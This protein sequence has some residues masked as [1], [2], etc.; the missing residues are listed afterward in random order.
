MKKEEN[1][2]IQKLKEWFESED[3]KKMTEAWAV[4]A[5][6]D[7]LHTKRWVD[8]FKRWAEPDMDAALEKLIAWYSSDKYRDREWMKGREPEEKLLWIAFEYAE[9]YCQ[10]CE[11]PENLNMFTGSAYYIGSYVIQ[12]MNGQGSVILIEKRKGEIK[13]TRKEQIIEMIEDRILSEYKKHS[14]ALPDSW[15]KIAAQKIYTTLEELE[16]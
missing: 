16:E 12:V 1:D 9:K 8:R 5:H 13:P 15:A 14:K 7:E 2:P 6:L 4:K 11:D 3:G 10:V